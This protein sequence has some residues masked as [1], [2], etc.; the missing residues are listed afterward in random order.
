MKS[1]ET[2]QFNFE[3]ICYGYISI[4]Q[5]NLNFVSIQLMHEADPQF[6]S[7]FSNV[8]SDFIN[9]KTGI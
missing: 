7:L 9:F 6:L 8:D 5:C 4:I 3:R 1:K 2:F